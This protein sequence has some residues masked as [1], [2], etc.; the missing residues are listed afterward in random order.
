MDLLAVA[1]GSS[2]AMA[3][4]EAVLDN[5]LIERIR[6]AVPVPLVLHG[7]SG[8]P[9]DGMVAAIRAGMTKINVSTHLNVVCTQQV[10]AALKEDEQLV[11]P[12][13]YLGPAD[14]QVRAEV[15]R[16]LQLYRS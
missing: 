4:R 3:T 9:D 11:D 16:L 13:K 2:H 8:V 6:Q 15:E 1:V 5:S 12:R 10:R 7:S 14:E